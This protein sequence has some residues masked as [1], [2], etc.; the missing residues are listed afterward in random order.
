[1]PIWRASKHISIPR[2]AVKRSGYSQEICRGELFQFQEVQLKAYAR[3][4][5]CLSEKISIPRGAVKSKTASKSLYHTTLFQF[6][7]VQLKV[8]K[9]YDTYQAALFQFQEVQLKDC[10]VQS[11]AYPNTDFNSKRCS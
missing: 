9:V 11:R 5:R 10:R 4:H 3:L 1:M 7:E 2:G 8:I 6:Q